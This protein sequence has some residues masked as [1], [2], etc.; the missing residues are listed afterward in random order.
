MLNISYAHDTLEKHKLDIFMLPGTGKHP[1]LVWLHSGGWRAGNKQGD[2]H[3]MPNTLKA[4]VKNGYAIVDINYRFST[5]AIFPAQI[6]DC[7]QASGYIYDN[8][9]RYHLDRRRIAVIGFSAG[10]HLA[11][12]VGLSNNNFIPDFFLHIKSQI[13]ASGS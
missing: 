12:L 13:S 5:E 4:L 7:N 2:M 1:V 3:Y 8:A 6:I 9:G 11:A 10:G